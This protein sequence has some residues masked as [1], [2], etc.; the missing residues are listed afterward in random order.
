MLT[1]RPPSRL[2]YA[3]PFAFSMSSLDIDYTPRIL[4]RLQRGEHV[5]EARLMPP[6]QHVAVVI[7]LNGQLR[8]AQA[9]EAP[10]RRPALVRRAAGDQR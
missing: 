10:D 1:T 3:Q 9:F 4:W 6:A 8:A 2:S 5:M 7:L